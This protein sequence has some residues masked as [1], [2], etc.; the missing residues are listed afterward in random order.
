MIFQRVHAPAPKPSRAVVAS[1]AAPAA[2]VQRRSVAEREPWDP[3]AQIERATRL[4]HHFGQVNPGSRHG[5]EMSGQARATAAPIQP[6]DA[7]GTGDV[8]QR[9]DAKPRKDWRTAWRHFGTILSH[10]IDY[11]NYKKNKDAFTRENHLKLQSRYADETVPPHHYPETNESVE[12]PDTTPNAH[13]N[14]LIAPGTDLMTHQAHHHYSRPEP[15]PGKEYK[16]ADMVTLRTVGDQ[17]ELRMAAKLPT[18]PNSLRTQHTTLT[19]GE[20][21]AAAALR[22]DGQIDM[23]S[24]HYHPDDMAAVKLA[25]AGKEMGSLDRR[26]TQFVKKGQNIDLSLKKRIATVSKWLEDRSKPK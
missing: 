19:G 7:A 11:I 16:D 21:V 8:I 10:P 17:R 5:Q 26:K 3:V 9:K 1:S 24:G 6:Q 22:K 20:D 18:G 14:T 2:P 12:Y 4:G 23:S 25:I 13:E 15:P